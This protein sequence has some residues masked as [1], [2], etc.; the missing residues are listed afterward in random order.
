MKKR[1][2][3]TQVFFRISTAEKNKIMR[4]AKTEKRT[5]SQFV[6]LASLDRVQAL[7]NKNSAQLT[8]H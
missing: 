1:N 3:D 7:A 8:A 2:K 5:M 6:L 4:A